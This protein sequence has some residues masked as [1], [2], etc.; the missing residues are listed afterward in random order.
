MVRGIFSLIH[1]E[2]RGLHE[3]AYLLG[4]FAI[5]SQVLALIRDR[6]LA[7][8]FGAGAALD[9]YYAAFRIP[10][11][12]FV[13]V[14]SLVSIYVLIP[15]LAEKSNAAAREEKKF[16]S[17]IFSAFSLGIIGI[18]AVVFMFVPQLTKLLFPG[19]LESPHSGDLILLTRIM[20]L[21]PIF[22]G[23]SSLFASIT[24]VHQRFILYA[25]SPLLYN[26]GIIAGIIFFYPVLGLTGLGA[27]IVLGSILH[28]SIQL[29]FIVRSGFFPRFSF[30]INFGEVKRVLF[31]SL[32]RTLAL[33]ANQISLLFL[34]A[35]ASLM[36]EGSI[37]V[38][39]FS[40]NL[41]AVPLSIIGVS[42]SVAAFPTLAKLY[43]NGDRKEFLEHVIVA[44]RHII[45]WSAPAIILFIVLRAQIVRVILGSGAF[46]WADTRLTAAALA[47]FAVSIAAQGLILLFVRGY[48]AAGNTKKPLIIN[49]I[50]AGLVAAFAYG[51]T[52]MFAG[53]PQWQFFIESLLRVENIAGTS[54]L[55][56]PLGYSLA[57]I[58]NAGMFWIIFQKDFNEFSRSLSRTFF[59]SLS[60][61]IIM[62]FA[63]YQA[64]NILDNIF[65]LNTFWG[66]F[67][68]GLFAGIVGIA[69]G[70]LMLILLQNEEIKEVWK[71][72]HSKFWRAEALAPEQEEI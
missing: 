45:F 60:A 58:I 67:S 16:I 35:F 20:L 48:Y 71:S 34:I 41:Q 47:L 19:L 53:V 39:N 56:L 12:I 51:F 40:F 54:V 62:G 27:G 4:V 66:I 1:R 10:D 15:F 64:L 37:A 28:L 69:T 38:F 14:A 13:A 25:T 9:V 2:I 46:D 31:L 17:N 33:S 59:Q 55:M 21:Q 43:S 65:D 24:Q 3:A 18:S 8:Y 30:S 7:H 61:S 36:E 11:I 23:L 52:Q 22:L 6:M 72:L 32:P 68:Q 50:S 26:I 5:L 29:P 70:V 57:V 44:A 63:A 42:Y 49:L